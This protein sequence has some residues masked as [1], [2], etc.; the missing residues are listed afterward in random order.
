MVQ[1]RAYLLR[2]GYAQHTATYYCRLINR[3]LAD[4]HTLD[5]DVADAW[6]MKQKC[7]HNTLN[8]Y[9]T[10]IRTYGKF[11]GN[12]DLQNTEYFKS[13]ETFKATLSQQE[14]DA[15]L[16]VSLPYRGFVKFPMFWLICAY[17]GARESEVA[18]LEKQDC[19]LG[20][21]EFIING[22]KTR[23]IR[24]IP[25]APNIRNSLEHYLDKCPTSRLF[26]GIV[27]SAWH[28]DFTKRLGVLGIK[29]RNLS[30][31]SLRHSFLNE[32]DLADV[33]MR[34]IQKIAGHSQLDTTAKYLDSLPK[35]KLQE[36]IRKHPTI[37]R[38]IEPG[39]I[40]EEIKKYVESLDLHRDSRFKTSISQSNQSFVFRLK[41]GL[42]HQIGS[43][44]QRSNF[45]RLPNFSLLLLCNQVQGVINTHRSLLEAPYSR[46]FWRLLSLP[47]L[48]SPYTKTNHISLHLFE[49]SF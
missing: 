48:T 19:D 24:Y 35:Q 9:I 14:L 5:K 4:C 2:K 1:F 32:L 10:S 22:T 42:L 47:R 36:A 21:N 26:P 16:N 27:N 3:L 11:I 12:Q 6:L 37:R 43:P 15:F 29:R 30:P 34:K 13:D 8:V 31:Y 38:F 46:S 28:R 44:P 45:R 40:F 23:S 18:R 41:S 17:T 33:S 7:C 25:I 20:N 39:E 49:V